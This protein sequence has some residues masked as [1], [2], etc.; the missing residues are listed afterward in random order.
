MRR[1]GLRFLT[2]VMLMSAALMGVV[3]GPEVAAAPP[4]SRPNIILIT[5]DDQSVEDLRHM[6]FTLD[7][8]GG[9][10]VTFSD[11]VSPYPLCCPAR[12]TIM[13]GLHAHNHGVLAN[14]P[15]AGGYEAM[16]RWNDVSLP[17]WLKN[18]GYRTTFVGKYLN[19]Y[20]HED[21]EEVPAGWDNW[22]ASVLHTY[23]YDDVWMN[24]NG[25]VVDHA[26]E[27]QADI[28]QQ[29]TEEAIQQGVSDKQPFFIWQSNLAPHGACTLEPDGGC[30]WEEAT[31]AE[32]DKGTYDGPFFAEKLP[33]YDER[34][35]VD[36]PQRIQNTPRL[37]LRAKA[38][39]RRVNQAN[40]ES[41][42]AVDRNVRDT[43]ELLGKVGEL[44]NTLI[45]FA[46]D[47]GYLLGQHRWRGKVLGYDESL[48]I[49]MLM[50]GPGV[51]AGTV[52][53]DMVSLVD[54]AA[55]FADAADAVPLIEPI[56][57]IS[58]LDVAQGTA[59]G[60]DAMAI[61]AGPGYPDV[62]DDQYLYRGV[63]TKRYTYMENPVTGE[64]ELYD[65]LV[66]PYELVN[67]AYRPT[68][69]ATKAA[70]RDLLVTLSTCSGALCHETS[71]AVP[72]PL[73][74]EGPVHPDELG[75]LGDSRQLVTVTG[76]RWSST[77]GTAVAWQKRGRTWRAVRGPVTV[78]LGAAGMSPVAVRTPETTPAGTFGLTSAF[79]LRPDPGSL[80]RYRLLDADDRWP[81]DRS[82]SRTYNVLE[83]FRSPKATWRR[84]REVLFSAY[85][86]SFE[87]G[88]VVDFNR[89]KQ[90]YWS[91]RFRQRMARV[92]SDVDRGSFLLHTGP[93]VGRHGWVSLPVADLTWLLR[94][95]DPDQRTKV[96]VGTPA[97]LRNKL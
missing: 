23:D 16:R 91:T 74:Q 64:Q 13:T 18:V 46:S 51:P 35:V 2:A 25:A 11:A 4:V 12:A 66:D 68:H 75:S 28:A 61:E 33:S 96:V 49:P 94:W 82:S 53:D 36:K 26:G 45:V 24:D 73:P 71:A 50:R 7:L 84:S 10:G 77:E 44:D 55:T 21:K 67:V 42:Q 32:Q 37:S 1:A 62:P 86:D 43:V 41:L 29:V 72:D 93:R 56:D 31:P 59:H 39:L 3:A 15:P 63:R 30:H 97:Y 69:S 92:P 34:V 58:L 81:H 85:P 60:Y 87:R 90:T 83:P 80:L 54:V 9:G 38:T 70:L 89:A 22:H 88:V 52:V 20:G 65:R 48:R 5:T 79:G 95:A 19:T 78:E 47:N 76:G 6:P 57:G 40:I 8:L 27:Y 17:V 14:E